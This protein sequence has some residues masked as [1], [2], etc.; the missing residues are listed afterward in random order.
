LDLLLKKGEQA[1]LMPV[2]AACQCLDFPGERPGGGPPVQGIGF[3]KVMAE[4]KKS[5]R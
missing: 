5:R 1:I 2:T 4:V 3:K